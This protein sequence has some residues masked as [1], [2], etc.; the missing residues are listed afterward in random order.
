M[1]RNEINKE[2]KKNNSN[3]IIRNCDKCVNQMNCYSRNPKGCK[4][5]K[6]DAPDGGYYG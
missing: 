2:I 6:K 3:E 1:E 4:N 5:Y